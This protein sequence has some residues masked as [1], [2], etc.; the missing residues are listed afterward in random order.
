MAFARQEPTMMFCNLKIATK[1][2]VLSVVMI[3]LTGAMTTWLCMWEVK[4]DLI[5]Q[6]NAAQESRLKTFWEML[7]HKG[8]EF[9]VQD[10]R[11]YVGS[12]LLN[13][14]YEVPDK[15]QELFGGTATVFMGD[16]R[17]S[18]NV[19][20]PDGSRAVGTKL[21][22]PAY[23]AIFRKGTP[24]RGEAPILGVDYFTAYDPIRNPQGEVIG[25]LYVGVKKSD[26]FS[27]YYHLLIVA[28]ILN[29]LLTVGLGYL[30]FAIVRRLMGPVEE[31]VAV[32]NQV[33]SGDLTARIEVRSS[34][35][36]GRLMAATRDMVSRLR[37]IVREV[38]NASD[39]VA[40]GSRQLSAGA[41]QMARGA[42]E[43]AASAEESASSMEEMAVSI[44]QNADNALQ[45]VH[46]AAQSANDAYEGG[47]AV[48]EAVQ[49][50][51][52]IA[53]RVAVI[54]EIARQTNL[55]AL[56]AAIEAARAGDHGRGF[57]VV[58]SEVRKLAERSQK[59]AA[60]IIELSTNSV[61]VVERAGEK[62]NILVPNIQRTADLV[63]EISVASREQDAGAEQI[64]KAIQQLD[65][66]VQ[67][68]AGTAEE[69][70]ST[71]EEL[72]AQ[73]EQ[74]RKTISFFNTGS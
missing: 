21:Q 22:G 47:N 29:I 50:M 28:S 17:I 41:D 59:A 14:N 25:V 56:N 20:K 31:A 39:Y 74:L 12:T 33:A 60:E 9:R 53:G 5:Q 6:A 2:V 30:V 54:D 73:S 34:D 7:R 45:T 63:A 42:A 52:E 23:D 72:S 43:Q 48:T 70:A 15:V 55:L 67:Q 10:G 49:A 11:M 26:F 37:E 1:F 13:D 4:Q 69:I 65:Q 27:G 71:A 40:S 16:T 58:A 57:A 24:Y 61:Q 35:E 8:G 38:K 18:T 51:Q 66:V 3:L 36:T 44:K 62:L 68:N 32:A 64:N 19:R 46:I